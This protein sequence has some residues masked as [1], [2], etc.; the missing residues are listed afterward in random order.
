M[1]TGLG[2]TLV[3][4]LKSGGEYAPKH[5]R[6]LARQVSPD[7]RVVCLTDNKYFD[8]PNIEKI[9]LRYD[10]PGWWAKLELFRP[11]LGL[12]DFLYMDLDTRVFELPETCGTRPVVLYDAYGSAI[13]N[14]GLMYLPQNC[15]HEIWDEWIKNPSK[16]MANYRY[17]G[18]Q[19]VIDHFW[20]NESRWQSLFPGEIISYKVDVI[21]KKLPVSAA[22]IVYFHGKPRPW[23]VTEPWIPALD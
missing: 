12:G 15:R 13:A 6:W 1:A 18:D 10:Y 3:L 4:V 19:G 5:V 20:R 9:E 14:S 2:N 7:V 16:W 17:H 23:E 11:D 8:E 22:K 21:A